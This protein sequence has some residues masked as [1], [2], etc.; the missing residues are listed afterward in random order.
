MQGATMDQPAAWAAAREAVRAPAEAAAD[1]GELSDAEVLRRIADG[2]PTPFD[3]LVDRYKHR[4][5]SHIRRRINDP[6]RAE[7]LTQEVFLRLFRAARGRGYS[8]VQ[9]SVVTWLFTI[10]NNCVIDHLRA[11]SRR[12]AAPG[13]STELA[14]STD[15]GAV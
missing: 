5:F 4:L 14:S 8:P 11:E 6:H 9:A 2:D 3:F 15:P 1:A 10:A 12:P 7:D 13:P